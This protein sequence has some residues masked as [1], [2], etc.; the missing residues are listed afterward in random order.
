MNP[1]R[2]PRSEN[3]QIE[4]SACFRA[5]SFTFT[6]LRTLLHST[7]SQLF[8]FQAIPNSFAKTPGVWGRERFPFRDP[9]E[10]AFHLPYTLPSSVCRNS[11]VCH[12]YENTGGHL[13]P[14]KDHSLLDVLLRLDVWTFGP[15]D[16]RTFLSHGSRNTCRAFF[17]FWNSPLHHSPL[18]TAS[19]YFTPPTA[20]PGTRIASFMSVL[21]FLQDSRSP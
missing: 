8:C 4:V 21:A 2:S 15:S 9:F 1:R 13:L 14:A 18:A 16:L 7:K 10:A 11:F 5:I 19:F 6:L 17:P 3:V 12:S 20:A